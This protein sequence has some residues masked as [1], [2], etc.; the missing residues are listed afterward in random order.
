[1]RSAS[2]SLARGQDSAK[3]RRGPEADS[4]AAEKPLRSGPRTN[5]AALLRLEQARAC[6]MLRRRNPAN[7]ATARRGAAYEVSVGRIAA[8]D[9]FRSRASDRKQRRPTAALFRRTGQRLSP[10]CAK[11]QAIDAEQIRE[12]RTGQPRS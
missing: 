3:N 7:A 1:M 10:R 9:Q 6:G 11:E 12:I 5:A 4:P 2:R 8:A